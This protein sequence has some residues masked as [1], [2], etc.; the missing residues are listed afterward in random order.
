MASTI[1]TEDRQG[2]GGALPDDPL[3]TKSS[4]SV[5]D[6]EELASKL[7]GLKVANIGEMDGYV[8]QNFYVCAGLPNSDKTEEYTM[9]VM[10]ATDS[11]DVALLDAQTEAILFLIERGFS[12]PRPI[13][14]KIGEYMKLEKL[15]SEK[16]TT[17]NVVRLLSYI[18][19]KTIRE[20]D[21]VMTPD[22]YYKC[23]VHVGNID[24]AL[25]DF[26]H[27]GVQ[28]RDFLWSMQNVPYLEKLSYVFE[29]TQ[30]RDT[31]RSVTC[32]FRDHVIPNFDKLTK[33]VIHGDFSNYN[34]LVKQREFTKDLIQEVEGK[35]PGEYY[36]ICG[37]LDFGCMEYNCLLFE[38][39][40]ALAYFMIESDDP[41]QSGGHMLAGYLSVYPLSAL[42]RELL[43][44]CIAGRVSQSVT[45][46][47]YFA[48]LDPSNRYAL[49]TQK[50]G[51]KFLEIWWSTP[52]VEVEQRWENIMKAYKEN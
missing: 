18:P 49:S 6:A 15:T 3:K 36:E 32:A 44:Y 47:M 13:K 52:K 31:I 5:D 11:K 21:I 46:G 19:G 10:N 48:T 25:R 7:Y 24:V 51:W 14:L 1:A 22:L 4:L 2:Q 8:D 16:G 17:E 28:R 33:G 29:E 38:I 37:L 34:L 23:G 45:L 50:P 35:N 9:K 20:A 30:K 41:I 27:E 42:E 43:Y 39:A 12:C 40:V 26:Y